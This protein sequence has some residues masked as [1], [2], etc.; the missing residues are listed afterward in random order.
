[1]SEQNADACIIASTVNLYY[2]SGFVFTGYIYLPIAGEPLFFVRKPVGLNNPKL[3]YIRKPE[4]IPAVLKQ[5]GIELPKHLLLEGDQLTY[6]EFV[7]LQAVF[8]PEKT[9][10]A[11]ILLRQVRSIK[12]AWEIEQFRISAEK[13]A[14]VYTQIKNCYSPEIS[15]L[16]FQAKIEYVMRTSGSLGFFRSFGAGMDI[17]MGS[18]LAGE[19]AE[20]PSPFDYAMGGEGIDPSL[21]VGANGTILKPG[22]AVMIDMAGNYTAYLTDMTRTFSV[23]KLPEIAYKAHQLSIDIQD[24]IAEKSKPG[25][26]CAE[27]YRLSLQMVENAGLAKYFM[28]TKQQAKFVGH[29]VGLEINEL[30]VFTECSKELLEPNI[31]FALEPKFVLP[32]IGAVGIENTFLVTND[33]VEKLTLFEESIIELE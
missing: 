14:E 9:G 24:A 4:D 6:N 27:M 26:S 22:M 28:G 10:N 18:I 31:V 33:G 8:N 30:P 16:E 2:L 12:T 32:E 13:H 19:N 17:H 29:G 7:R 25:T 1:M 23:G 15:D 20:T 21:P 3:I 5:K 11:T